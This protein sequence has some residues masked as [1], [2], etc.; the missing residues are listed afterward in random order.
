MTALSRRIAIVGSPGSGKSTFATKLAERADLPLHHLD[1][2]Y[3]APGWTRRHTGEEWRAL[4]ERLVSEPRW[5][6]DG[7]YHSTLD[8][9]VAA[10]D[11][12]ILLD[13]PVWRCLGN[14]LGRIRAYRTE[15]RPDMA[16]GCPE[17]VD[18][19]L[20][21]RVISYPWHGRPRV[22]SLAHAHGKLLVRLRSRRA[23]E[24]FLESL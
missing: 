6:I 18:W 10:A 4:Q 8:I 2:L 17:R 19:A 3:W 15:D 5:I 1:A 12:V 21:R 13:P 22:L 16:D 9:R 7:N 24:E 20:L 11:M 14:I 23:M